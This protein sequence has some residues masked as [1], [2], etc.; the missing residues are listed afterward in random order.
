MSATQSWQASHGNA[1]ADYEENRYPCLSQRARLWCELLYR[2]KSYAVPWNQTSG[3][4][5]PT[6]IYAGWSLWIRLGYCQ[7]R[8]RKYRI[9]KVPNGCFYICIRKLPVCKTLPDAGY[10]SISGIPC[11]LLRIQPWSLPD[12]GLRQHAGCCQ[13]FCRTY[14]KGTYNSTYRTLYLLRLQ[15]SFLQHL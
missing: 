7:T 11:R 15:I 4:I 13:T 12:N 8:Y 14:W 1:K 3:S 2:K 10:R 9:S 5:Y 6:G